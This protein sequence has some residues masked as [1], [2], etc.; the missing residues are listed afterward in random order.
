M[1]PRTPA[2]LADAV[3]EGD[4]KAL[5]ILTSRAEQ[6]DMT[7][8]RELS[9][10]DVRCGICGWTTGCECASHPLCDNDACFNRVTARDKWGYWCDDHDGGLE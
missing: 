3:R 4:W 1:T 10:S 8:D 2:E 7:R 5:R 9:Y 6:A